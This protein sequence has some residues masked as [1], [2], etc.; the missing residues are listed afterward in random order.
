[1]APQWEPRAALDAHAKP[2][3]SL[4]FSRSGELVAS[5]SADRS[6]KV[7]ATSELLKH[8]SDA[9]TGA[10]AG[11]VDGSAQPPMA[12]ATPQAAL[13]GHE[14]GV[15]DASW[16]HDGFYLVS[17][18]DD[19]TARI[20]DVE[21]S[22]T[23]STLGRTSSSMSAFNAHGIAVDAG[24]SLHASGESNEGHSSF[25]FSAQFNPQ[26]SLIVTSSFDETVRFWDVRTGRSVAVLSA[27]HEPI[28]SARFNHDGTLLI[29]ASYDGLARIWD[30]ATRECLRTVITEPSVPLTHAQFTPNS[31]FALFGT[32]DS[33]VR[34]WDYVS[35][36]CLKTYSGHVSKRFCTVAA[37][38]KSFV[39]AD[40]T[41]TSASPSAPLMLCGSEDGRVCLWDVQSAQLVEELKTDAGLP[42]IAVDHHPQKPIVVASSSKAIHVW[43]RTA[44]NSNSQV[45]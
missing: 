28:V 25:V 24:E 17:A 41:S 42:V 5:A 18:S 9:A 21:Y 43:E 14:E 40:N 39:T 12:L 45:P 36:R 44:R 38:G 37:F 34:L 20:W 2:I 19:K 30:V 4:K 23:L 33:T 8:K 22:K 32:L 15:N 1:M 31:K 27:H 11:T 16:S 10:D 3:S 26:G 35:E 13:Y 6:V 7:W 29:T